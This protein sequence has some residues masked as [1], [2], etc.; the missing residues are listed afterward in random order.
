MRV[1]TE[2]CN[3]IYGAVVTV[4]S[5][6]FGQY[7]YLFAGFLLFNIVDYATGWIYSKYYSKTV[8]SAVG[9]KGVLKKVSYWIVIA[10]AFY[11]SFAFKQM[12][13]VIGINL[14]FMVLFGWFTLASYM[15]NEI[16]SILENLIKMNVSVPEF[17]SKG[18]DIA[19]KL[20]KDKAKEKEG[21][22]DED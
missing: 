22:E 11:I 15:I 13:E 5:A 7:W 9:A 17:L 2:K 10:I 6:V 12:G 20:T 21:I 3:L 4:L 1:L 18:L 19:E 16:R 14:S 8:S